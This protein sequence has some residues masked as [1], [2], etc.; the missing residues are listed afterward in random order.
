MAGQFL[1]RLLVNV[2]P[3]LGEQQNNWIS[4]WRFAR[5]LDMRARLSNFEM[6]WE[7]MMQP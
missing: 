4:P 1:Q 6:G 3:I 5:G 2:S 7:A